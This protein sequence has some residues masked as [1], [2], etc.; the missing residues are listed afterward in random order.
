MKPDQVNKVAV[1][2]CGL[3]GS[4]ITEVAAK[5]GMDATSR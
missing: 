1:I 4:G 2:G 5:S 3:M